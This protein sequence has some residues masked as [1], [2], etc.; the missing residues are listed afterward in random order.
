M[1]NYTQYC[2]FVFIPCHTLF[3]AHQKLAP[4]NEWEISICK[5]I[6]KL[7]TLATVNVIPPIRFKIPFLLTLANEPLHL[8]LI[9]LR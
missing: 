7:V 8:Q 3:L 5:A 2:L 6:R 9:G 4:C 1:S